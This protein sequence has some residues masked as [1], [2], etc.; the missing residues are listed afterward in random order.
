[1]ARTP[2]LKFRAHEKYL[3]RKF[4]RVGPL[5]CI[6]NLFRNKL[7]MG[8]KK[9]KKA[10]RFCV[11]TREHSMVV[12]RAFNRGSE[13][14]EFKSCGKT[15]LNR[16]NSLDHLKIW[17][18]FKAIITILNSSSSFDIQETTS[19]VSIHIPRECMSTA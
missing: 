19:P 7:R 3:S 9:L 6:D 10:L 4:T 16:L 15:F 13:R 14:F 5:H 11:T 2:I 17:R 1:M 8:L 12:N 18:H